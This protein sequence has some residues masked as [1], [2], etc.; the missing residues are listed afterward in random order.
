MCIYVEREGGGGHNKP[1]STILWVIQW[2]LFRDWIPW[3]TTIEGPIR[4]RGSIDHNFT[5]ETLV[6]KLFRNSYAIKHWIVNFV[7]HNESVDDEDKDRKQ[8]ESI[9][10]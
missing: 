5:D 7:R 3:E 10:F 2:W 6:D 9:E 8:W 4:Y 1:Y